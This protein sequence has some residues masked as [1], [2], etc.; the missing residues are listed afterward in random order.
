MKNKYVR[1]FLTIL[2]GILTITSIKFEN[3]IL[4]LSA[5]PIY[6]LLVTTKIISVYKLKKEQKKV[7]VSLTILNVIFF[8]GLGCF[9]FILK[10]IFILK[11]ASQRGNFKSIHINDEEVERN[12]GVFKYTEYIS[13][14]K[15][16]ASGFTKQSDSIK[17]ENKYYEFLTIKHE[18]KNYTKKILIIASVHGDEP[19]GA[20]SIPLLLK[21]IAENPTLYQN[22]AICVVSPL[23]SVGLANTSRENGNGCNINR[24][25]ELKTQKETNYII[26]TIEVFKPDL[27]LD[28]HE[29]HG[30]FKTCLFANSSV[31]DSYGE[32]ICK[33]L[34]GKAIELASEPAGMSNDV[35]SPKG[36]SKQSAYER[37]LKHFAGYGD[38][39][40]YGNSINLP[41][42]ALECDQSLPIEKRK[43]ICLITVKVAITNIKNLN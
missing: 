18:L 14:L 24:D 21:D 43:S 42:I 9:L 25:F 34:S 28:I 37:I 17:F 32:L 29:N 22:T 11:G 31:P 5:I 13:Q 35:L 15:E 10:D 39:R 7:P 36:W 4:F 19:A 1:L 8:I 20:L 6:V 27:V 30:E 38:L 3:L 12:G 16:A 41:V 2:I 40:G 33:D 26:K 23:N